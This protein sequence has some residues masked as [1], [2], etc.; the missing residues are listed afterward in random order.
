MALFSRR[1]LRRMLTENSLFL[2]PDQ[3]AQHVSRLDK[4]PTDLSTEWEIA[5]LNVLHSI[6]TVEH[7]PPDLGG[8]RFMDVVFSSPAIQFAADIVTVSD[9]PA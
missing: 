4:V 5:I 8:S 2:Q 6:G 1:C 9:K 7:E 3:V